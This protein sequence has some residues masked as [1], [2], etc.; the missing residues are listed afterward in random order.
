MINLRYHI[1]SLTAV[2]LAIGIG[3][4]LGST[5]LDRATVDNLNG[6]LENLET[7]LQDRDEQINELEARLG[8]SQAVQEGLDE[9]AL[10]LLEGRL[11]GMPVAVLAARGVDEA[12]VRGSLQALEA[13]DADVQGIYWFTDRFALD[14]AG[15]IDDLATVL[16]QDSKDPS[17]LR[18]MV[19]DQLGGDLRDRQ[20]ISPPVDEEVPAGGAGDQDPFPTGDPSDPSD[21]VDDPDAPLDDSVESTESDEIPLLSALVENGFIDFEAVPG[22]TEAP[23]FPAGT[24][25]LLIGGSS[26]VPDDLV[27]EPLLARMGTTALPLRIVAG[28]ARA[29][30]GEISDLVTVIREDERFRELVS[31]VDDLEHFDGWAAMVLALGDTRE[32]IVGHYGIDDSASRL[33]P[34]LPA[35]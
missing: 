19:L 31:T 8:A 23:R 28:S 14:D 3:L 32:G 22:A 33:L 12:D 35:S 4:T 16:D 29:N 6:Q 11:D 18:R 1:V 9:Q 24:R 13:A 2:F 10:G 17:R 20:V 27:V 25:I 5:F 15:E 26:T 7:R 34:A 21:A 30:D